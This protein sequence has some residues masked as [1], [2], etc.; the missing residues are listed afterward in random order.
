MP[1]ADAGEAQRRLS[2]ARSHS[3]TPFSFIDIA[4]I[5]M[6]SLTSGWRVRLLSLVVVLLCLPAC[7]G[8]QGPVKKP[9]S[10]VVGRIVVDGEPP[11]SPVQVTCHSQTGI[12]TENPTFSS[13]L[14]ENDGT[15]A[16]NTYEKGDGVPAGEYV[17]TFM[18]GHMNLMSMQYGGPDK[19]KG[20]YSDPKNSEFV[21]GVVEGLPTDLGTIELTTKG[22]GGK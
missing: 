12:D 15:F 7:S 19:F 16:I 1:S 13:C 20:R 9:T 22:D 10:P 17:L 21:V 8:P 11:G 18:W 5:T 3:T 4:V 14:S 2:S 6:P